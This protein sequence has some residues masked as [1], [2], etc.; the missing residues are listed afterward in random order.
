MRYDFYNG[1]LIK[2][3]T[4]SDRIDHLKLLGDL[5]VF[6]NSFYKTH[7]VRRKSSEIRILEGSELLELIER[8]KSLRK[9]SILLPKCI[10]REN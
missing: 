2:G 10:V 7:L 5:G 3:P 1:N 9:V 8:D 4:Y 6:P